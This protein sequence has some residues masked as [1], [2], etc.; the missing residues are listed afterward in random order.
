MPIHEI[1]FVLRSKS[2]VLSAR[3]FKRTFKMKGGGSELPE[4]HP[5]Y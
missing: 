3:L 5:M 1:E 4:M 2:S